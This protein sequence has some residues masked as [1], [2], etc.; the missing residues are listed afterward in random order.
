VSKCNPGSG[1]TFPVGTTKVTCTATDSAGNYAVPVS[2]YVTVNNPTLVI[3]SFV[4][5]VATF[6]CNDKIDDESFIDECST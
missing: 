5:D 2:F 1:S 4:R 6:W 3:P